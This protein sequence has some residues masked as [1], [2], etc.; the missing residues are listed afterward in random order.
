MFGDLGT[1]VVLA[2]IAF[3]AVSVAPLIRRAK[4]IER[5]LAEGVPF[6]VNLGDIWRLHRVF[7]W[8]DGDLG[9][10]STG[11][12]LTNGL[13]NTAFKSIVISANGRKIIQTTGRALYKLRGLLTGSPGVHVSP[14]TITG[15]TV[16]KV[17]VV[18]DMDTIRSNLLRAGRMPARDL[19]SLQLTIIPG[20][21]QTDMC[22]GGDGGGD[23]TGE[24][25]IYAEGFD[26]E[27]DGD[28]KHVGY[29]YIETDRVAITAGSA[30]NVIYLPTGRR[31]QRILL[32]TFDNSLLS[33]ALIT[34]LSVRIGT[35]DRRNELTFLD[36]QA[37]NVELLGLETDSNGEFIPVG[38]ALVEFARSGNPADWLDTRRMKAKAARLVFTSIAPTGT[39]WV[40]ATILSVGDK[41]GD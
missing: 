34:D 41:I 6:T 33:S 10:D 31:I 35:S 16:H 23:L 37:D 24:Y 22:S 18:I 3:V 11:T 2:L 8:F 36:L 40:N 5:P 39:A 1:L 25:H 15:A 38:Y 32:E 27:R 26:S 28:G 21:G 29:R 20:V 7:M 9:A 12:M 4:L 17:M 19:D 13:L 30:N 14:A